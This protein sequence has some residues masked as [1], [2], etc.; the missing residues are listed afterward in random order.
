MLCLHRLM[1]QSNRI[2]KIPPPPGIPRAFDA[3]S[4]PG[5]REFDHLSLPGGGAFDLYGPAN[6]PGP[7]MIPARKWSP[8]WTAND[9]K[10]ENDPQ[11]VPQTIP[12][13]EMV[14]L[15]QMKEMSGLRN[16]DSGFIS[17]IFFL[18]LPTANLNGTGSIGSTSKMLSMWTV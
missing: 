5:G 8:N 17:S 4:C 2:F 1:Y 15:P 13:T 11:I 9:P 16:L 7:Q 3:F 18:K 6:D 14:S 10:T 12:R